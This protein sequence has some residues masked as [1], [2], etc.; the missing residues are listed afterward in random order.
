PGLASGLPCLRL[1]PGGPGVLKLTKSTSQGGGVVRVEGR[2]DRAGVTE[3]LKACEGS[4]GTL[5]LAGLLGADAD[6]W[7]ALARL[8]RA[9][10]KV[11]GASLYVASVLEE[12]RP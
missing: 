2:L 6:G 12:G 10:W 1:K 8:R 11:R 9:G 7:A 5:D 3:L 4:A